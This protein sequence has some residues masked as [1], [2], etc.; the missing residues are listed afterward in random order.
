MV[1]ALVAYARTATQRIREVSHPLRDELATIERYLE[2]MRLRFPDRLAFPV[3]AAAEVL[4]V[5]VPVGVLLIP[6]ENAV[7]HGVEP[8]R[9]GGTVQV[10]VT[11]N[12]DRLV[13]DILDDGV[14]LPA[15]PPAGTGLANLRQ[16]L[17]LAHGDG[18]R[19]V[20]Q[21]RD[22]GGVHVQITLPIRP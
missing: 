10:A 6:V 4:G 1:D 20:V 22:T 21:D 9:G 11:R 19:L 15:E 5:E 13:L 2:L 16:R 17:R 8:K 3:E 12:N 18:A 7:K 14:G